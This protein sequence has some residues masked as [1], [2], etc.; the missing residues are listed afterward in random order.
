MAPRLNPGMLAIPLAFTEKPPLKHKRKVALQRPD[1]HEELGSKSDG[2]EEGIPS[3][4][5]D[6][7]HPSPW[8]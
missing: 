4:D 7:I 2:Q 1:D 6:S 8:L 3:R 5:F